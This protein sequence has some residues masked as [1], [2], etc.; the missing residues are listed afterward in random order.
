MRLES[1]CVHANGEVLNRAFTKYRFVVS[2][3]YSICYKSQTVKITGKQEIVEVITR[4]NYSR[5]TGPQLFKMLQNCGSSFSWSARRD[6][7][8]ATFAL[9]T[10]PRTLALR[11]PRA[12]VERGLVIS[13]MATTIDL[14]EDASDRLRRQAAE[15]RVANDSSSED[16]D[17]FCDEEDD[18]FVA[19]LE[20]QTLPVAAS[21][22]GKLW[23]A[24]LLMGSWLFSNAGTE[25]LP[26][27]RPLRVLELGS[28]L[29][30]AG[31][32]AALALPACHSVTLTDYDPAVTANL[33]QA[34]AALPPASAPVDVQ[35]LDFRDFAS[36]SGEQPTLHQ[37]APFLR[38]ID[39]LI[40]ADVV[41]EQSHCALA[42]VVSAL[43]ST[44]P[45][46]APWQP[47]AIFLLPDSRP[48]LREFVKALHAEGLACTIRSCTPS[49]AMARCLRR[50]HEGWGAGNAT[51]SIYCVTRAAS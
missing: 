7:D 34:A 30:V 14:I 29:A 25:D 3:A 21:I 36:S 15:K 18:D 42:S 35:P 16:D 17:L 45:G 51:F 27:D 4:K 49:P 6:M 5:A 13:T 8:S 37:Y 46:D 12:S 28:G 11:I 23:D 32:S 50:S 26:T 47:R 20:L 1:Y 22:G 48:R 33:R 10:A 24:S 31:L 43:L 40:A 2:G 19:T 38:S 41:Y 39:L 9:L 44:A